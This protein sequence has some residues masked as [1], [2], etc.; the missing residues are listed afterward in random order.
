VK[1]AISKVHKL[2]YKLQVLDA[3]CYTYKVYKL[4]YKLQVLDAVCYTYKVYISNCSCKQ[5]VQYSGI[6]T[7]MHLRPLHFY[8]LTTFA[9][10]GHTTDLVVKTNN[11]K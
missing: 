7:G 6:D 10:L 4:S 5:S 11:N 8:S 3:V 9:L 2:S 1:F